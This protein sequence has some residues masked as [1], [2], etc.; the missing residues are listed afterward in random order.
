[1]YHYLDHL[2]A[3]LIIFVL[4]IL[5]E[6][7]I[8]RTEPENTTVELFIVA[9]GNTISIPLTIAAMT[10]TYMLLVLFK[11]PNAITRASY[12]PVEIVRLFTRRRN[13]RQIIQ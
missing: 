3:T 8:H 5:L 6:R 1:M 4:L 11:Q 12:W 10:I 2:V 9:A 13:H 7:I